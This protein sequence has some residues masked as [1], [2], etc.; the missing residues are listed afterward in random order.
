MI[1]DI[2]PKSLIKDPCHDTQIDF[3]LGN[4]YNPKELRTVYLYYNKDAPSYIAAMMSDTE[5][6]NHLV[7]FIL[8]SNKFTG[9]WKA[10]AIPNKIFPSGCIIYGEGG[11]LGTK[12]EDAVFESYGIPQQQRD[13]FYIYAG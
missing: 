12:L 5:W 4:F 1:Q 11:Y 2:N 13:Y 8:C 6:G 9:R 7:K 3:H 10:T